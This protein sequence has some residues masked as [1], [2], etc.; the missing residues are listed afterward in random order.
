M[1]LFYCLYVDDQRFKLPKNFNSFSIFL[2]EG[3]IV[4][5]V[6]EMFIWNVKETK[7]LK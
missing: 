2:L 5:Y 6:S 7:T 4:I 3:L 1:I